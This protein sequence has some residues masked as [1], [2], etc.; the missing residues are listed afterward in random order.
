MPPLRGFDDDYFHTSI[1]MSAL[2]ACSD[3]VDIKGTGYMSDLN[4]NR[5]PCNS[6]DTHAFLE[7]DAIKTHFTTWWFWILR[8]RSV[9]AG[10]PEG[11]K[12][13]CD[14]HKF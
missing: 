14:T 6:T 12:G 11:G 4:P 9:V 7:T 3:G 13:L 8:R 5:N 1:I 2:R 10:I